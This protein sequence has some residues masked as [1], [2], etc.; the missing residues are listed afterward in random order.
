MLQNPP[1]INIIPSNNNNNNDE[2]FLANSADNK[3][4]KLNGNY[5]INVNTISDSYKENDIANSCN[6]ED[7]ASLN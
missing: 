5:Q 7:K 6:L 3:N 4:P 1:A 2:N